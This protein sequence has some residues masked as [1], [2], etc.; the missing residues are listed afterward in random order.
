MG[1]LLS[2]TIALLLNELYKLI[3]NF[4]IWTPAFRMSLTRIIIALPML[5]LSMESVAV[6]HDSLSPVVME[7]IEVEESLSEDENTDHI[8]LFYKHF[9]S[10]N[11]LQSFVSVEHPIHYFLFPV[12]TPDKTFTPP[13]E[14]V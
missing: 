11:E 12:A 9:T 14:Q 3:R 1:K 5:L 6:F 10:F 13:P 7:L 4:E 8:S 2:N